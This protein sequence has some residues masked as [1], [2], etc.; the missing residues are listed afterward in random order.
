MSDLEALEGLDGDPAPDGGGKGPGLPVDPRAIALA[1]WRLKLLLAAGVAV[2]VVAA[3]AAAKSM[4]ERTYRAETVM[5]FQAPPDDSPEA[6]TI[7][8]L[9]TLLNMV[10]LPANLQ[11][12][13]D[14]LGLGVDERVLGGATHAEVRHGTSLVVI[15]ATWSDPHTAA[16]IANSLRET[17]LRTQTRLRREDAEARVRDV[18]SRLA[19]V[20]SELAEAD[21]ALRLFS[22]ENRVVH[23]S[24]EARALLD[25]LASVNLL[26]EEARTRQRTVDLQAANADRIIAELEQKAAA[27][28]EQQAALSDAMSET[29]IRI[30]RLRESI[31]DD[32]DARYNNA[33][34]EEARLAYERALQSHA[35]G[36]IPERE[37][38]AATARFRALEARAV[39]T[40]EIE[41]W[42]A[43]IEEL[44]RRVIPSQSAGGG[45]TGNLLKDIM[46]RSFEIR[47]EQ[48]TTAERVRSMEE[49]KEKVEE[50]L[51]R[52]PD[53][54]RSH[55]QLT[56]AVDSLDAESKSLEARLGEA[57]R[58]LEASALPFT[59][60][61][62]A[63]RPPRSSSSNAR[64]IGG[65]V[66]VLLAGAAFALVAAMAALDPRIRTRRELEI[67]VKGAPSL[68]EIP[69]N[70]SAESV[71]KSEE[72]RLAARRLRTGVP[73]RG[74]RILVCATGQGEGATTIA[75]GLARIFGLW[76]EK[77]L[78]VEA[79]PR[80][81]AAPSSA[82]PG[83]IR[84]VAAR[85]ARL[86]VGVASGAPPVRAGGLLGAGESEADGLAALLGD[87]PPAFES[88]VCATASP[89][90]HLLRW[91]GDLPR[92][93]LAGE[94]FRAVLEEASRR[95]DLVLVDGPAV[96][97]GSDAEN[98]AVAVDEVLLVVRAM[99][100]FGLAVRDAAK[101]LESVQAPIA[102]TVL[103]ASVPPYLVRRPAP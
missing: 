97:E 26:L 64:K 89:N 36:L 14:E 33:L 53:L 21:E 27:E 20:R 15:R 10:K 81:G 4:A 101:S 31:A 65:A 98:I 93:A 39:D 3:Y 5:L 19:A 86:G 68:G 29:N 80:C 77:V 11:A 43:E 44:D 6:Q 17:F 55:A 32:R 48:T 95:F 52:L 18:E 38:E 100:P 91:G 49:A 45:F 23:L 73:D 61:A 88:A 34:L 30:Q 1:L 72:A 28:A 51:A 84:S 70:G 83:G 13:S 92:D 35:E 82:E 76:G 47:L 74:A 69:L 7:P 59:L 90:V 71:A 40:P 102:A 99:G 63:T 75:A 12:V 78:V 58:L 9:M 41:A 66:L 94:R 60:V 42:R 37:L 50:R 8:S 54:E 2:A 25:E 22:R 103:N 87:A 85:A 96:L 24:H 67:A 46:V 62:E 57:R 16:A 79:D 56:R